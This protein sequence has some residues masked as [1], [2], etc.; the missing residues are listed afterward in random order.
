MEDGQYVEKPHLVKATQLPISRL[1]S[2]GTVACYSVRCHGLYRDAWLQIIRQQ[3]GLGIRLKQ[4]PH[5]GGGHRY[6]NGSWA[7]YPTPDGWALHKGD[8]CVAKAPSLDYLLTEA[9]ET[10]GLHFITVEEETDGP[11]GS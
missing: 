10:M 2:L 4:V 5:I 3:L 6:L 9:R 11:V 8:E 7:A 1:S